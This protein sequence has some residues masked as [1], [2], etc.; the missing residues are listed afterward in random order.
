MDNHRLLER[1]ENLQPVISTKKMDEEHKTNLLYIANSSY[2]ARK[3]GNYDV[4]IAKSKVPGESSTMKKSPKSIST[5][6]LP[7]I[8]N[9]SPKLSA[10][11]T[12]DDSKEEGEY[13][14]D[15]F[16]EDN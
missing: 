10:N 4:L 1:L 13:E 9:G 6:I 2:S 12:A 8:T 14:D 3:N 11:K 16:E 15:D 5:P 7:A